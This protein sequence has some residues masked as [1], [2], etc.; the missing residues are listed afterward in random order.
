LVRRAGTGGSEGFICFAP[1]LEN[2]PYE[3]FEHST[4]LM[5]SHIERRWVPFLKARPSPLTLMHGREIAG[6]DQFLKILDS[7]GDDID[8]N[9][10][11]N[12]A[13]FDAIPDGLAESWIRVNPDIYTFLIDSRDGVPAGYINAMPVIEKAYAEIRAGEKLDHQITAEDVA[14]FAT[15]ASLK[16]YLMSIAI[17]EDIRNW[18][19]GVFQNSYMQLL[20]GFFDKL[21]WYAK[22]EKIQVTH[23]LATAWTA[24][25][26]RI[27][28][29]FGMCE[30]GRN[31]HDYPI[32]ELDFRQIEPSSAIPPLKRLLGVYK[33]EFRQ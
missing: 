22:N 4:S 23:L 14:P 9:V 1:S 3:F 27:C 18:G 16:M 6:K 29:Q 33:N 15:K 32:F 2:V 10:F 20:K 11:G 17:S 5:R 7:T 25:G 26:R 21:A 24:E 30:I 13:H 12:L 28:E 8:E 31:K 19:Q